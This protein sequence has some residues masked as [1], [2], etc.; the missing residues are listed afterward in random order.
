MYRFLCGLILIV[1]LP[2]SVLA[3]RVEV[4]GV[5]THSYQGIGGASDADKQ[6]ALA[7]AKVSAWRN[8]VATFNQAKQKSIGE[9]SEQLVLENLDKFTMD[10]TVVDERTDTSLK[11]I[12]VVV[13]VAFNGETVSQFLED[14][15]VGGKSRT[16]VRSRDSAFS[17]LFLARKST[18]VTQFDVKTTTIKEAETTTAVKESDSNEVGTTSSSKV[19][20]GGSTVRKE[21]KAVYAMESAED[22]D[23]AMGDVLTTAG[24][25]YIAYNDVVGS[26]AGVAPEAIREE[27]VNADEFTADT[28]KKVISAVRE[29]EIKYFAYGTIDAGLSDVD[30]VSGNKRVFVSVRAKLLD[31]SQKL[32]RQVGSVGPKQFAGLG[33]DQVVAK[34]NALTVAANELARALVDQLNAKGIR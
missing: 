12:S 3:Q 26:C 31:V 11:I 4:K 24:I 32:P 29:C 1:V 25:D 19:T 8:F 2:S 30:P 5:G 9:I 27:F 13:R 21:D 18:A 23:A 7:S 16:A 14:R 17:F 10:F 33:P 22:I 15:T 6:K 34:R 20:T 28:R